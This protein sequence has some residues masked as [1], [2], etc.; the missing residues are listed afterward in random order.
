MRKLIV[1]NFI[2][3]NGY[4]KGPNG[5]VIWHIHDK[6]GNEQAVEGLKGGNILL[7]GR[8][9]YD[10][11]A[12]YWPTP[13]AYKNDPVLAEGMNKAEKIVFSRTLKKA[14]WNN[15]RVVKDNTVEEIQK[16]K[17]VSD[18][19]NMVLMGSGTISAQFTDQGLIDRY[20]IL[21][22]PI[23][24]GDGTPLFKNIKHQL[25]FKLT[26]T[27]TLKSGRVLLHYEPLKK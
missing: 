24:I 10:M 15:S 22:D 14:E 5:D 9:T 21:V 20:E 27:K 17:S 7:F 1:F 26:T 11:M 4:F 25:N 8:V 3:L 13:N 12:S 19:R 18:S 6:E 16:M 2:T 23:A